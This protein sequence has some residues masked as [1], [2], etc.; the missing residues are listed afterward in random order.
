M[1]EFFWKRFPSHQTKIDQ[2]KSLHDP[3]PQPPPLPLLLPH[4]ETIKKGSNFHSHFQ[5]FFVPVRS[6]HPGVAI[7][8]YR[9]F[10][11]QVLEIEGGGG[12]EKMG[13]RKYISRVWNRAQ[14][15][16]GYEWEKNNAHVRVYIKTPL[17]NFSWCWK[18]PPRHSA[19]PPKKGGN[20]L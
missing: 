7:I 16:G 19:T 5:F 9:K 17:G 10:F 6:I 8:I 2:S 18:D 3:N 15:K 14:K 13:V 12:G 20:E 11:F 4:Q 1:K